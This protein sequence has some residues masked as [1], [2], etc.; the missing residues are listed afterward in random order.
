MITALYAIPTNYATQVTIS[1]VEDIDDIIGSH[2]ITHLTSTDGQIDF[3]FTPSA[4]TSHDINRLATE[5][6]LAATTSSAAKVPLLQGRVVMTA[7]D[8][9]GQIAPLTDEHLN[10][11]RHNAPS[12]AALWLLEWRYSLSQRARRRHINPNTAHCWPPAQPKE[13]AARA[14]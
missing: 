1:S 6:L 8:N 7:H 14:A 4:R 3:W 2:D 12:R 10:R 13:K 11:L 5:L 9:T